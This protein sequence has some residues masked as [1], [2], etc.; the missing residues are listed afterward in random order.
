MFE[1]QGLLG[2]LKPWY[3]LPLETGL[4]SFIF[5]PLGSPIFVEHRDSEKIIDGVEDLENLMRKLKKK[6]PDL[7]H[8]YLKFK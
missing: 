7:I 5:A 1:N 8:M 4:A 6:N 3:E 2:D